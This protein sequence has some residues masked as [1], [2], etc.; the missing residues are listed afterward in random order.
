M[1]W[2]DNYHEVVYLGKRYDIFR[3]EPYGRRL[4]LF[5]IADEAEECLQRRMAGLEDQSASLPGRGLS[6]LLKDFLSLKCLP[7]A[8]CA[9]IA[10]SYHSEHLF[11]IGRR[12]RLMG[13]SLMPAVPPPRVKP[14]TAPDA[15]A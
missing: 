3:I 15:K 2:D 1:A 12:I 5:L 14:L 13:V 6:V 7:L 9:E 4:T 10:I 11:H 8:S